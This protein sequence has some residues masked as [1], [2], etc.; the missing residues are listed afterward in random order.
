MAFKF[1][2]ECMAVSLLTGD[3]QDEGNFKVKVVAGTGKSDPGCAHVT[4]I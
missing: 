4:L 3:I 2:V 1:A